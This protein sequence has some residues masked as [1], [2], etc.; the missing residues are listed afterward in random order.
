MVNIKI[1]KRKDDQDNGD[2]GNNV[3][4]QLILGTESLENRK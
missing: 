4:S 1:Y 3:I 2:S